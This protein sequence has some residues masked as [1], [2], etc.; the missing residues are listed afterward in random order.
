[1]NVRSLGAQ[2]VS[3]RVVASKFDEVTFQNVIET[4]P[5]PLV[6]INYGKLQKDLESEKGKT[7]MGSMLAKANSKSS[8]VSPKKGEQ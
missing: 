3:A 8:A 6:R 2:L 7:S 4:E 5:S 1:M